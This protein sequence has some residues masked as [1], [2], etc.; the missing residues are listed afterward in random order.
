MFMYYASIYYNIADTI[1][2][3]ILLLRIAH[4]R[5]RWGLEC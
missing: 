4:E 3:T 2:A 1:A 5:S